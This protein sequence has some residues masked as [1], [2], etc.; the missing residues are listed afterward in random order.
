MATERQKALFK[1]KLETIQRNEPVYLGRLMKEVGYSLSMSKSPS[2]VTESKGWK[3]LQVKYADDEKAL[4][5]L[6]EL[7]DAQNTDKDNRLRASVEILKL[8][9]RYPASKAKIVGMFDKLSKV[10]DDEKE[11]LGTD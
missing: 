9:D 6:S 3:D 8:N 10:F 4:L 2:A 11:V 5:T 7:A 1:K